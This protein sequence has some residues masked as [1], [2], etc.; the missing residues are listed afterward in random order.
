M[1]TALIISIISIIVDIIL[2]FFHFTLRNK[3]KSIQNNQIG[4]I[5]NCENVNFYTESSIGEV[6]NKIKQ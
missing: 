2:G 1:S 3:V 4:S 5:T 6:I